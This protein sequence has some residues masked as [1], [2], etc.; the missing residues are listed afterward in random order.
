MANC[1]TFIRNDRDVSIGFCVLV[2]C[3]L[4][5]QKSKMSAVKG[6]TLIASLC[7]IVLRNL[8]FNVDGIKRRC[9]SAVNEQF[10]K[11]RSRYVKI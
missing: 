3:F 8:R 4:V 11:G 9:T 6:V 1:P 7:F 5:S 10:V 2:G